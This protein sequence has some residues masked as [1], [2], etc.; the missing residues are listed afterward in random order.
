VFHAE[1]Q[2]PVTVEIPT[3]GGCAPPSS[4]L[5]LC[6]SDLATFTFL[7]RVSEDIYVDT[8]L[9]W[10]PGDPL[11]L[12]FVDIWARDLNPPGLLPLR[13]TG[14]DALSLPLTPAGPE[15]FIGNSGT[16]YPGELKAIPLED[17]ATVLPGYDL[18]QFEGDQSSIVFVAMV[19]APYFDFAAIPPG[20]PEPST[21]LLLILGGGLLPIRCYFL[22]RRQLA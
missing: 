20:V 6:W 18:S 2:F 14:F 4:G 1:Y 9:W 19:D 8:Y 15:N 22:P 13:Q 3:P 17:L 5:N 7:I 11:P 10:H 16:K 21:A 12:T